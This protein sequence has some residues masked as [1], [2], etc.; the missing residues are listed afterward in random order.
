MDNRSNSLTQNSKSNLLNRINW[1]FFYKK[2]KFWINQ[3]EFS[4]SIKANPIAD[5]IREYS[6][7]ST[8]HRNLTFCTAAFNIP[9]N[10]VIILLGKFGEWIWS[11]RFGR[12]LINKFCRNLSQTHFNLSI[13]NGIRIPSPISVVSLCLGQ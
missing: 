11:H 1:Y 3:I 8:R 9:F 5:S 4:I 13:S 7:C 6:I 2:L 12:F 10:L